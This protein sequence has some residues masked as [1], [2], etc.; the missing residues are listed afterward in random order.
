MGN[1]SG[2][3]ATIL[4]GSSQLFVA[5]LCAVYLAYKTRGSKIGCKNFVH[6]VWKMRGIFTPLIVHIYDTATGLYI[7][8]FISMFVQVGQIS[9]L[10]L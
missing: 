3:T 2:T 8:Y 10:R 1:V 6:D 7:Y 9:R 5:L 4:Y